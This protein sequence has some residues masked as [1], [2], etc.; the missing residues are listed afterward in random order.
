MPVAAGNNPRHKDNNCQSHNI[1]YWQAVQVFRSVSC[2][3][4]LLLSHK[5]AILTADVA[6]C[7]SK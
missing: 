6:G 5:N 3:I 1:R 2:N 4:R 7:A